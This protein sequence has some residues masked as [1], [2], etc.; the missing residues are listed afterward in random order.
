MS[1]L[2][3][4]SFQSQVT[5]SLSDGSSRNWYVNYI[6][7]NGVIRGELTCDLSA[8]CVSSLPGSSSSGDEVKRALRGGYTC[9]VPGCQH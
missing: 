3:S 4:G 9:C 7:N 1:Q 2:S 8:S 6:C 5:C